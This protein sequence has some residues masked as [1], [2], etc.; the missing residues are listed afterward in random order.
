[1]SDQTS[2]QARADKRQVFTFYSYKG[3]VGRSMAAANMA[4][5]LA[6]RGHRVLLLDMD[7]EA[8][9]LHRYML[10][11][12]TKLGTR[13]YSP[14]GVQQG[15]IDLFERLFEQLNQLQTTATSARTE[16]EIGAAIR[17]IIAKLLDD[18]QY[19]YRVRIH[20][21]N[22]PIMPRSLDFIAAGQLQDGYSQQVLRFNWEALYQIDVRIFPLL[23]EELLKRYDYVLIDSRTGISDVGSICTA[24]LPDKLVLVFTTNQQSLEGALR[25]GRQALTQ[26]AQMEDGW[27]LGV[28][29]LLSRVDVGEDELKRS[30]IEKSSNAFSKL[31][32]KP[33]SLISP[34]LSYYFDSVVCPHSS[35]YAYGEQIAAERERNSEIGALASIYN[36]LADCLDCKTLIEAQQQLAQPQL[37]QMDAQIANNSAQTRYLHFKKALF[38][39]SLNDTQSAL[40]ALDKVLTPT[41]LTQQ[42][43]APDNTDAES[44]IFIPGL[45]PARLTEAALIVKAFC[46]RNL[47]RP[48][49]VIR[50]T[51]PFERTWTNK[52]TFGFRPHDIALLQI[53]RISALLTLE[54]YG[55][56]LERARQVESFLE[57]TTDQSFKDWLNFALLQQKNALTKLGRTT[58]AAAIQ[59]EG[60]TTSGLPTIY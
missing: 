16:E 17:E 8:P 38:L 19:R 54:R 1:M 5:V 40:A 24:L 31:L 59:V 15:A 42:T 55:E 4:A 33:H 23:R 51:D 26:R 22:S 60:K 2:T 28:F 10:N 36:H 29:P 34:R 48:D 52:S 53:A 57:P 47:N 45:E 3:G 21:P 13:R 35:Y 43:T 9:G 44:D 41:E 12:A 39:D 46:L 58:E 11:P 18:P 6:Q 30:W 7:L 20:N 32:D 25:V 27:P 56:S 50:L 14:Q 49:E 37:E